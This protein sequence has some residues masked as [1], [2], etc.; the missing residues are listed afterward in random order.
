[1]N[2]TLPKWNRKIYL[3][4]AALLLSLAALTAAAFYFG[5]DRERAVFSGD[6][7]AVMPREGDENGVDGSQWL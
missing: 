7:F 2:W 5:A 1:M 6:S 4:L 3:S